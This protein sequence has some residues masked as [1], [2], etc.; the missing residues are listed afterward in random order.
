MTSKQR[1]WDESESSDNQIASSN[2]VKFLPWRPARTIESD[3]LQDNILVE[4]DSIE[5]KVIARE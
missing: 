3:F 5:A 2:L 1:T 4:V